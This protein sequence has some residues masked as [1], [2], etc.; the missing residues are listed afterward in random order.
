[1]AFHAYLFFSDGQC[2]EAITRYQE[3][4]GGELQIMTFA[5]LPEGADTMPGAKPEH[6]MHS[7]LRVGD[8]LLMASDDPTGD[9]G[10]RLGI[11]VSYTAPDVASGQKAFDALCEGGELQMPFEATFWSPGFGACVDRWGVPWMVD[12]MTADTPA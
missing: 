3:I 10:A 1:M 8:G 4:F 5:D 12:T 11:C 9:G 2:K 6:V 7:S